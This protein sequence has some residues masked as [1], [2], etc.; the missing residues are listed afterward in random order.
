MT[1][2]WTIIEIISNTLEVLIVFFLLCRKFESRYT[3]VLPII[4]FIVLTDIAL[5]IPIFVDWKYYSVEIVGFCVFFIFLVTCR[6]GNILNKFFWMLLVYAFMFAIAFLLLPILSL[7]TGEG[8]QTLLLM[9]SSAGRLQYMVLAQ[10]IK[11]VIFYILSMNKKRIDVNSHSLI[12]CF[13]IPLISFISGTWI[14][15]IYLTDTDN[16]IPA[17][18]S[19]IISSSYLL[20]NFIVFALYE[21]IV[22]EA[23]KNYVLISK[24]KQY[25]LTEEHNIQIEQIYK[26][27]KTLQHD[28]KHHAQVVRALLERSDIAEAEKYLDSLDE[29]IVMSTVKVSTGNYLVDAILSSKMT[30]A[31]SHQIQF[32]YNA[33]LPEQ[34][35]IDNTDL[36]AVLSNLLDNAIEACRKVDIDSYIKCDVLLVKNQLYINIV[37]SSDGKYIKNSQSFL[38][39]K[40]GSMHGIGL[41]H[42]QSIVNQYNG[43]YTIKAESD[44]FETKISIPMTANE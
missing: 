31:R 19:Y 39:T 23:E 41:R 11:F 25:E 30:L 7:F 43:I 27:V 28:F 17:Q 35:S 5:C 34:L 1:L 9:S 3:S 14:Y 16:L 8:S 24:Q 12:L 33:A 10:T 32:E 37:N 40:K 6:K 15:E 36:C 18:L 38:T 22:K 13:I 44:Y 4:S 21:R 20:I 2:E 42:I 26:D 29:Q